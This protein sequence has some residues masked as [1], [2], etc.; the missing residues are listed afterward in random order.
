M[1]RISKEFSNFDV[2]AITKELDTILVNSSIS[3][4]YE[5]QDLLILKINTKSGKRNL[6]IKKDSRIN[7]TE[8]DYPIPEY[9]SQYI[10][11]VRKLL[12]NRRI[13][14]IS[15]YKFDRVIIIELSDINEGSWKFIIELF[16]K[17]N[18][19]L[20][21]S[22]NLIRVAKRYKKYRDRNILAK[23][24]YSYPK[25][26]EK[27]FISFNIEDF[28][29][30]FKNSENE[31]VR[32]LSRTLKISGLYSEE[33][34][35]R[36][37]VDKRTIGKDLTSENLEELFTAFKKLRNQL[38]FGEIDAHII[39][40]EQGTE[41]AVL[42]FE[43][44]IL[45][46]YPRRK[47]SSFNQAVDEFYSK[48]DYQSITVPKDQKIN[49]QIKSQQKIFENQRDYL[50][51]QRVEKEKYYDI[52]DFLYNNL[53]KIEKLISVILDARKKGYK[54][55]EIN[56]KLKE[57]KLENLEG[58]EFFSKILPATNQVIIKIKGHEV[59][60]DLKKSIGEN[61]NLIYSRGK[62]ADKKIKGT[63]IAIEETKEKIET[64]ELKKEALEEEINFLI[65]KP[66]KKWYEKF[67][68]F[69]STDGFLIIGGRDATSNEIIFK[70]YIEP[71]DLVFHTNIPGSPLVII[72]NPKQK[73]ISENTIKETSDFTASYSRAWKENWG[74]VDVFFVQPTQVTKTPPS[75]EYLQ[76]GSFIISGK[77]KI[78]KNASTELAI[79][80]EFVPLEHE[81]D[82]ENILLYPKIICGP[83]KAI[84]IQTKI[85]ITILPSKSNSLTKGKLAKEIKSYFIRTIAR[86]HKKWVELLS[87]DEILL[88]LPDGKS[89]FKSGT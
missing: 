66:K 41:S 19:L 35:F 69:K 46:Q 45:K 60:F 31:I 80:L 73:E 25:S 34:C 47:F 50:D 74:V 36:A 84:K 1:I 24:E 75:G 52:G 67:R 14:S 76:K 4:V 32:E 10:F 53:N 81:S 62:K 54:W 51:E 44:E 11:T 8:F 23:Q 56:D 88:Y 3:N 68:W 2:Y 49:D 7:L 22:S 21:D 71:K 16:N 9:P 39:L 40:D 77:K 64:L 17:G 57:A 63:I 70:R 29:G 26:E 89:K 38:L 43:V 82:K 58:A 87:V 28:E 79:G 12:K 83:E 6:I 61:A 20:L 15:Q 86:E 42:P 30:I 59:Y 5:V 85:Y 33:L 78:I 13:L 55:D 48:I 18:F 65:K 27:D 37:N 72:K